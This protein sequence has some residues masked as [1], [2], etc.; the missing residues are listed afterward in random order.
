MNTGAALLPDY[1]KLGVIATGLTATKGDKVL[2]GDF[3]GEGRADYM[4]VG[5]GGKV[6]GF[7]NRRQEKTL[8]PRWPEPLPLL[9]DQTVP[10]KRST[11]DRHD[12]RRQSRLLAS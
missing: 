1:Y 9:T 5:S 7:V 12:G 4:L 10:S 6:N 8:I 3:T 2:L 11:D